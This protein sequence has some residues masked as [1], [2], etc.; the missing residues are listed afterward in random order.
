[1]N[2]IEWAKN[3]I[4]LAC[5]K[6]NP[7]WDGKSFDYGCA[8]YQSA[9]KA[10]NSLMEDDHSGFSWN[11]TKNIL[12]RLMNGLPL[13]PITD[14]DFFI[15]SDLPKESPDYLKEQGL[16]SNIQCPRMTSLFRSET[17]DG[18]VSYSDVDRVVFVDKNGHSWISGRARDIINKMFPITMPY[19]PTVDKYYVYGEDFLLDE[20]NG[21][22][23][24]EALISVITPQGERIEL[25]EYY[26]EVDGK[27]VKI[28]KEEYYKDKEKVQK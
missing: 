25:D 10:Y 8:C 28:T 26:K 19:T 14:D 9:L 13:L 1:M 23:D 2:M 21:D 3:E 22:F 20:R 11:I 18:K 5:K 12:T 15:D 24:H 6:E 27:M 17:L 7:N 16:K 4:E